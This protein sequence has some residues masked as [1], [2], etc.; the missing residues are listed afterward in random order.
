MKVERNEVVEMA[1][2]F[3]NELETSDGLQ[4]CLVP[5]RE[6]T[7]VGAMIRAAYSQNP[8]WFRKFAAKF[9]NCRGI[10]RKRMQRPRTYI[11][12]RRIPNALRKIIEGRPAGIY[13][14]RLLS[15]IEIEIAN[16][17]AAAECESNFDWLITGKFADEDA[18]DNA[19]EGV[20]V[21]NDK[22]VQKIDTRSKVKL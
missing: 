15:F 20:A 18:A 2:R 10:G 3:L 1:E 9:E 17:R 4:V 6:E 7:N 22:G 16:E 11:D 13:C 12:R 19:V 21:L 14:E 8:V 5:P